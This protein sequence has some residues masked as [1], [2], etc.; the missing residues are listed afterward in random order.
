MR[1]DY[2][3]IKTVKDLD[4][5][6]RRLRRE[7]EAAADTMRGGVA[8]VK[9]SFAPVHLLVSG[10][11]SVSGFIPFDR[12]ALSAIGKLKARLSR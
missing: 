1:S 2:S 4:E 11:K 3:K 6:R 8:S 12:L 10:L 7:I 5:S 9:A